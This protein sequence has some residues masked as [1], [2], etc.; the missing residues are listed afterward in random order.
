MRRFTRRL[1][2]LGTRDQDDRRFDRMKLFRQQN[3]HC[4]SAWLAIGWLTFANVG[5]RVINQSNEDVLSI[6]M[7][8][9]AALSQQLVEKGNAF[10]AKNQFDKAASLFNEAIAAD[11]SNGAA[12]NNLGLA[13]FYQHDF[14][15]A[16]R[17]FEAAHEHLPDD[18]APLNNLG[19]IM[20]MVA[21]PDDALDLYKQAHELAPN[22]PE[23]LGNLVRCRVRLKQVDEEL[24]HQIHTLL[25]FERRLE[26]QDWAREQL[27]LFNNPYHDRGP[28]KPSG[29]PLKGLNAPPKSGDDTSKGFELG[30]GARTSRSQTAPPSSARPSTTVPAEPAL[31]LPSSATESFPRLESLPPPLPIPEPAVSNAADAARLDSILERLEE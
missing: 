3:V 28:P 4:L 29:D 31:R 20:E 30:K 17:A 19:L 7:S 27:S 11:S 25:I 12:Y 22:N 16:G 18:P 26:W 1:T 10:V 21:R 13:F 9:Q 8:K 15:E 14:H 2:Q 5:C 23:Y 6:D 24:R